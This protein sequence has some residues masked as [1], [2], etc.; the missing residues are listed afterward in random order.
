MQFRLDGVT[1]G[2]LPGPVDFPEIIELH[3]VIRGKMSD[4]YKVIIEA[5]IR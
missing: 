1:L 5:I 4:S 3:Q 2:I